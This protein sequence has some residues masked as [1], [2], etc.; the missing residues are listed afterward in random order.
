[1]C[2]LALM[3]FREVRSN[4]KGLSGEV[5]ERLKHALEQNAPMWPDPRHPYVF[6]VE[7]PAECFYIAPLPTGTVLLLARWPTG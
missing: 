4:G 2:A 6:I 1:M 5:I 7:T 3:A